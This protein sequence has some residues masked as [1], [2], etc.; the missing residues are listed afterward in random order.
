MRPHHS[1]KLRTL[2]WPLLA[3]PVG[4][5]LPGCSKQA[6]EAAAA[7]AASPTASPSPA[8]WPGM[9]AD[10]ARTVKE[11]ASFYHFKT[12]AD[13]E[14]DTKGLVWEDGSNLPEYA[15]PKAKKGGTLNLWIP[16]F[17]GTLRAFGP[18]SNAS[19]RQFLLDYITM[20]FVRV[21]PD[22]PGKIEPAIATSW[23]VDRAKKTIYFRLDPNVKWTDGVPFTTDDVVFSWYLYRSPLLNDPWI[24]DYFTKTYTRLTI[25]DA[26]TF[27]ATLADYRPD[28]VL[29]VGDQVAAMPPVPRHA[30]QDFGPDWVQKFN[31]R[32]MPTTGAYALTEENIHRTSSVTLTRVKGWWGENRR[33]LR[34]LFNPDKIRLNVIH[35]PDKSVEAFLH[36]DIDVFPLRNH[37]WYGPVSDT[38]PSVASGFTVKATFYNRTPVPEF[39]LWINEAMPPLDNLELR[40]GIAY[41]TNFDLVCRQYFRGDASLQKTFSDGYGWDVNPAVHPRPFDPTQARAHF[42]KAGYTQEGA[43]GVLRDGQGKRLSF[44]ITTTYRQYQDILIILKQEAL[45]AGLEFNIEV[46]DETTGWQKTQ[47]KRHEITLAAFNRPV[48]MFPR[49]WEN[50]SG[51]NA[52][53]VPYLPDGSPNPARKVKVSTNN[54]FSVADPVMDKIIDR[55]EKT[56][57]MD[58]VRTLAAQL[59]QRVYD[60]AIWVNGWKLPFYR[61]GY[62]PWIKWPAAFNV[63]QS[64]DFEQYWMMW[65]DEDEQ[66]ADLAKHA[67]GESLPKQVLIFDKFK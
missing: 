34:N 6:P 21:Y 23:A 51:A 30:F 22:A 7:A 17:P 67:N 55:Y 5:L 54:L 66:K 32:P 26:H 48:D 45:K 8:A 9:E 27:S 2:L 14:V 38:S 43:D 57:T 10:L 25:Y 41:A 37:E 29:R 63:A 13:L 62:R 42:A 40:L 61:V 49:Y 58:E 3:L 18:D 20:S 65:I 36:G 33:F 52:Y 59:E 12:A 19:F 24:N 47:D 28:A 1:A 15:D 60:D 56:E 4:L 35:D 39:G 53:D 46:L 44:T 16:D 50:F 64:L 31:W 11:Q